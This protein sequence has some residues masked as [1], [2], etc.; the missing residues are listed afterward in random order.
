MRLLYSAKNDRF[1][2]TFNPAKRASPS[3]STALMT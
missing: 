3:S 1:G 2:I